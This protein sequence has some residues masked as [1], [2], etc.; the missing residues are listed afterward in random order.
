MCLGNVIKVNFIMAD[1]F[2]MLML[3]CLVYIALI[4]CYI[5]QC[6]HKSESD[7]YVT[8]SALVNS[9]NEEHN[10]CIRMKSC[11][12]GRIQMIPHNLCY[13]HCSM[14]NNCIAIS[15][16][17]EGCQLCYNS[18][19]TPSLSNADQEKTYIKQDALDIR[20]NS[21]PDSCIDHGSFCLIK[22]GSFQCA[23]PQGTTGSNCSAC[24]VVYKESCY[25]IIVNPKTWDDASDHCANDGGHLV[26]IADDEEYEAVFNTEL[27]AWRDGIPLING[28][29]HH[30]VDVVLNASGIYSDKHDASQ[31]LLNNLP[32]PGIPNSGAWCI[33]IDVEPIWIQVWFSRIFRFLKVAIRGLPSSETGSANHW[34]SSFKIHYTLDNDGEDFHVVTN[35]LGMDMVF[36]GNENKDEVEFNS[37]PGLVIARYVRLYPVTWN[38]PVGLCLRW[39]LYGY[40]VRSHVDGVYDISSQAWIW[41]TLNTPIVYNNFLTTPRT[42]H[43][44]RKCVTSHA[45]MGLRANE[46]CTSTR[47]FV[48]EYPSGGINECLWTPC[49]NDG[50]CV[51]LDVGYRC[52][53]GALYYGDHCETPITIMIG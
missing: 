15:Y 14:R 49:Q 22:S 32:T 46:P 21:T 39:E 51:N 26:D 38:L 31:S 18:S 42:D 4:N 36:Q 41:S 10:V 52:I 44:T 7:N 19:Y 13:A 37:I 23:C 40:L 11:E 34:V 25:T 45:D 30:D 20:N 17:A 47:S 1:M 35:E 27:D 29:M 3:I 16:E 43:T 53:C 8:I 2:F 9:S 50:R 5:Q 28:T 33:R 24:D 6:G 12:F 48:C